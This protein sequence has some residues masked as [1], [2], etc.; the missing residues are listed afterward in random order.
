MTTTNTTHKWE[1]LADA[2]SIK[3]I[4]NE[5]HPV[6]SKLELWFDYY[7]MKIRTAAD[8]EPVLTFACNEDVT[9]GYTI[10]QWEDQIATRKRMEDIPEHV[11]IHFAPSDADIFWKHVWQTGNDPYALRFALES[12][13]QVYASEQ[14]TNA[15]IQLSGVLMGMR[16][17]DHCMFAERAMVE[18]Y[19]RLNELSGKWF[20]F[21]RCA[22]YDPEQYEHTNPSFTFDIGWDT[23]A[24]P[25][26]KRFPRRKLALS[27]SSFTEF[28][29]TWL[30]PTGEA[31]REDSV[32]ATEGHRYGRTSERITNE[33][34]MLY[35]HGMNGNL[36]SECLAENGKLKKPL[37]DIRSGD[38]LWSTNS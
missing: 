19:D 38:N 20:E 5:G 27:G 29:W 23:A 33:H 36:Q 10:E 9:Q 31:V 14:A 16:G 32:L 21:S 24:E 28:F 8:G 17:T 2:I 22:K 26:E 13:Y 35:K 6:R 1:G 4:D 18:F 30:S 37:E 15:L 7:T 11:D 34:V 25:V 3:A 12:F